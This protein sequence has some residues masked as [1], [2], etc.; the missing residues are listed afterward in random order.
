MGKVVDGDLREMAHFL[1][2]PQIVCGGEE[3]A[4]IFCAFSVLCGN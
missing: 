3:A 2:L 4:H 1:G